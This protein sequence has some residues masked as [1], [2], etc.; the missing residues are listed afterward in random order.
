MADKFGF[1]AKIR[2]LQ[3]AKYDLP[4]TLA[5]VGQRYFQQQFQKAQWDGK[6][7]AKRKKETKKTAGKHLLVSS[8]RLRQAMQNTIISVDWDSIKWGVD[9][10]VP[11]ARYLNFG[12]PH[13]PARKFMGDSKQLR[14]LFKRKIID[15]YNQVMK[16]K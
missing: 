14:A 7:W 9:K 15:R 6:P 13:M 3:K 4:K 2:A 8:G 5:Q 10:N 16:A 11:Y 12:T 1:N